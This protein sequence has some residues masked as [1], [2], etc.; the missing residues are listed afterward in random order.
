[1]FELTITPRNQI[2]QKSFDYIK[3]VCD[4]MYAHQGK[5]HS[6][7]HYAIYLN[8]L[9]KNIEADNL[10]HVEYY[11]SAAIHFFN[12]SEWDKRAS[13]DIK[14]FMTITANYSL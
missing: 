3:T 8:E 5:C 10:W 6:L 9:L 11:D 4:H 7:M 1:M 2:T 13:K 14:A 12:L